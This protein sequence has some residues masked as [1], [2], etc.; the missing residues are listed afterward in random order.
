MT[1]FQITSQLKSPM[2]N[3]RWSVIYCLLLLT[4]MPARGGDPH[5]PQLNVTFLAEP[6]PLVQ[7][8]ATRLYYEMVITNFAKA[9]YELES[10]AA[11]AG[12]SRIR[13]DG[14]E[15]AQMMRPLG[16]SAKQADQ[17]DRMVE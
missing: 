13:F 1:N 17:S 12:A 5:P 3:L 15:L 16:D 4:T 7:D 2:T 6:A 11:T 8:G 10:V 9:P 14:R